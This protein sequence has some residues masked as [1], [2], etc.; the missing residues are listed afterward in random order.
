MQAE[1]MKHLEKCIWIIISLI[2]FQGVYSCKQYSID[3]KT[4]NWIAYKPGQIYLFQ[5]DTGDL[6]TLIILKTEK[7]N[8]PEDRLAIISPYHEKIVISARVPDLWT[9]PMGTTFNSSIQSI[10]IIDANTNNTTLDIFLN[11]MTSILKAQI[12][13]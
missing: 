1:K 3:N 4:E 2:L 9:N 10:I 8:N 11:H 13:T 7:F 6:D 5:D 12:M